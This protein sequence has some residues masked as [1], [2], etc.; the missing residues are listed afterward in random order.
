VCVRVSVSPHNKTET[1]ETKIATGITLSRPPMKIR[2]KGQRSRSQ[3]HKVQKHIES[4]RVAGVSLGLLIR[5]PVLRSSYP[6]WHFN[7]E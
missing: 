2:S 1:Y 4:D 7:T 3:G 6:L 5:G